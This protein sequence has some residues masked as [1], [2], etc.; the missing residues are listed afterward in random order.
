MLLVFVLVPTST[1]PGRHYLSE[2]LEM[3]IFFSFQTRSSHT[4]LH[5]SFTRSMSV[6]RLYVSV[7]SISNEDI[8]NA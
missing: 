5:V 2:I 3:H 6:D 8:S 4:F 7:K 1:N